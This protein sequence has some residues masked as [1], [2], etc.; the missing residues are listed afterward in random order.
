MVMDPL[1]AV[2]SNDH[3]ECLDGYPINGY[4]LMMINQH[5]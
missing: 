1:A 3:P 5:G 2:C 4:V